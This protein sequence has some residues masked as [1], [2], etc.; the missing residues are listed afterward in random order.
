[1]IQN[2]AVGPPVV[3]A[4]DLPLRVANA[5]KDSR[6]DASGY[7]ARTLGDKLNTPVSQD[8]RKGEKPKAENAEAEKPISESPK[9]ATLK[10]EGLKKER[11]VDP[12][13]ESVQA[14]QAPPGQER[15][16]GARET[17]IKEFMD[18]FE[19]EFEIPPTRIVEAMA[20]IEPQKMIEA[21]EESVPEVIDKLDLPK[22]DREK[23]MAMYAGLISAL[24]VI[25]RVQVAPNPMEHVL[26]VPAKIR[27]AILPAQEQPQAEIYQ[28][29][30]DQHL[31]RPVILREPAA[32]EAQAPIFAMK[33]AGGK[34]QLLQQMKVQQEFGL[35]AQKIMAVKTPV[36]DDEDDFA[37][38]IEGEMAKEGTALEDVKFVTPTVVGGA[39]VLKEIPQEQA[40]RQLNAMST[41]SQAPS[42]MAPQTDRMKQVLAAMKRQADEAKL[43]DAIQKGAV[44]IPMSS[45]TTVAVVRPGERLEAAPS[46]N[47]I[48]DPKSTAPTAITAMAMAAVKAGADKGLSEKGFQDRKGSEREGSSSGREDASLSSISGQ[49]QP[50]PLKLED[51][52]AALKAA[53]L[54][55][56]PGAVTSN[57]HEANMRQIINQAQYLIKRGGGEVKVQMTP[58]G[59]GTVNLKI[60][61]QDGKVNV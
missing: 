10:A 24:Q 43:A 29:V 46:R 49:A 26:M 21:P 39:T 22:E 50:T 54:A 19:S 33:V 61:V 5:S 1:M 53:P 2:L 11:D 38:D 52:A 18:S 3:G 36:I 42:A 57:D 13:R 59:L 12:A 14:V 32:A 6:E 7:F 48:L 58:E 45:V 40:L 25:D 44:L 15:A 23:A 31:Q 30:Q 17:A 51:V 37:S 27:E 56:A 9:Q 47:G 60:L 28:I 8:S 55:A 4:P 35:P 20:S 34:S 41:Q 16:K